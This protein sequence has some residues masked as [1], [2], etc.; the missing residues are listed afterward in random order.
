MS[1]MSALD[2]IVESMRKKYIEAQ[3]RAGWSTGYTYRARTKDPNFEAHGKYCSECGVFHINP[4]EGEPRYMREDRPLEIARAW[5][6]CHRITVFIERRPA[7]I[8]RELGK[9]SLPQGTWVDQVEVVPGTV[10]ELHR[11]IQ[12]I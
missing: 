11:R 2:H 1:D 3:A 8:H 9:K 4:Y 12:P 6:D 7:R 10:W 5:A